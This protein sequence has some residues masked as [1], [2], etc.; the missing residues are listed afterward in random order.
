MRHNV[1]GLSL[2]GSVYFRVGKAEREI[3]KQG[4]HFYKIHP[5][6]ETVWIVKEG[7]CLA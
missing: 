1:I 2:R 5:A 7:S 6:S 4:K 3:K